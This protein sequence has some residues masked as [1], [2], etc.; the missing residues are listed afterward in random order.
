[1]NLTIF[2]DTLDHV[3]KFLGIMVFIS[4]L[5]E[6]T[7]IRPTSMDLQPWV[8]IGFFIGI[9]MVAIIGKCYFNI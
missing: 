3:F 7:G 5:L 9:S 4:A 8:I 1:M 6:V 2:L